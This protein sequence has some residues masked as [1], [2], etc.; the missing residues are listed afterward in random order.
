MKLSEK[1]YVNKFA[2][3]GH[4]I[5]D[6][7]LFV[8]YMLE[9]LKGAR[10]IGYFIVMVVFTVLPVLAEILIYVRNKE[11]VVIRHVL[12]I[13]YS[14]MY[15][16][17]IFTTNSILTFTYIFPILVVVTVYSDV[18][19]CLTIGVAAVLSNIIFVAYHAMTVG[20]ASAELPDVEIRVA[21][22]VLVGIY[23]VRTTFANKR[24][25]NQKLMNINE[26]KEKTDKLLKEILNISENMISG[27]AEASD[28]MKLLGEAVG[29]IHDSMGEVS[30]GSTETAESVQNQLEQTEQIQGHIVRVKDTTQTIE[31]NTDETARMVED[32]RK[33]ME[34]LAE[35]VEESMEANKQVL[36]KMD[37]LSERTKKMN[38]IIE[39]ITSIAGSTG[40]LALNASIEAARA[41]EAGRGFAVVASEISGLASQTK[42]ATVNITDLITDINRELEE[43][44]AAVDVV[45]R[46]NQENA[47]STKLVKENFSGIAKGTESI[48]A[49]TKELGN[50]V[51]ALE[52]ANADIVDKIQTISAITEEVSAHANETYETCE[53]NSRMV[54]KVAQ[55]VGN[56]N[57]ETEK[58]KGIK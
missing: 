32:G 42:T 16:F 33:Q 56:L 9:L 43:V 31:K 6:A 38:T 40:M 11:S 47:D 35:Q 20:Y 52:K 19:Q 26:Q 34:A 23:M 44:S 21:C 4:G 5:I 48:C 39:T 51:D 53:E 12:A 28:K 27:I 10:S 55:I 15:V 30:M 13:T 7:I 37:E 50:I 36:E 41:G 54:D 49:Q 58:L 14:I 57:E 24:I 25:N 45:T 8:A 29:H 2:I 18:V 1:A 46:S 3:M 17:A 22:T